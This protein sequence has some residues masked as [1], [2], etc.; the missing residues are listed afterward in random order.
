MPYT[1]VVLAIL[2]AH[3]AGFLVLLAH[4]VAS[5]GMFP[6]ATRS[7]ARVYDERPL[8]ATFLGIVTFGL[9]FVAFLQNARIPSGFLRFIVVAAAIAGLLIALV[10]SAGLA[11][12]IGRNL[13][14]NADT[15]PQVLRGGVML[16]LVLITP[17]LGS[18]FLLPVALA[19]GFGAFLL[20][21]PWK[22][23]TNSVAATVPPPAPVVP[24][25]VP[26]LS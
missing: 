25:A 8:K 9:L 4:W 3:A 20:T 23:A 15:W 17:V 22:S 12:R 19:S 24:S 26:S 7:F 21:K 14:E 13:C 16:A 1:G 2:A 18:L 10:G 5:A 6:Q 11:L